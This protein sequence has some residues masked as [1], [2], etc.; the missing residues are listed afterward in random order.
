LVRG[1]R[2]G[3]KGKK[4]REPLPIDSFPPS[5]FNRKEKEERGKKGKKKERPVRWVASRPN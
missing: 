3:R 4:R 5:G 1:K 2:E